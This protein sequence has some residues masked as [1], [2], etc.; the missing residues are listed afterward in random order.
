LSSR[1]PS[2]FFFFFG[3]KTLWRL[4][5]FHMQGH[6]GLLPPR[7]FLNKRAAPFT[8]TPSD[9]LQF[10]ST[11]DCFS[12]ARPSPFLKLFFSLCRFFCCRVIVLFFPLDDLFPL[13]GRFFP[14]RFCGPPTRYLADPSPFFLFKIFFPF[15]AIPYWFFVSAGFFFLIRFE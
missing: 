15:A 5:A 6:P 3:S 10:F 4:Y 14:R 1:F 7:S 8:K 13:P 9:A 2:F 11:R 12:A